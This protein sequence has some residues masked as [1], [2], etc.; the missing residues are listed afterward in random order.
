MT[1][2]VATVEHLTLAYGRVKAV[3]DVSFALTEGELVCLV[4]RN[5]SGKKIGRAHV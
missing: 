1:R 3:E 5:G 2:P 4:G